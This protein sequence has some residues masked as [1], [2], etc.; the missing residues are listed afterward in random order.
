MN[1]NP[2]TPLARSPNPILAPQVVQTVD[3]S[4]LVEPVVLVRPKREAVRE[5]RELRCK[6]TAEEAIRGLSHDNEIY[7]FTKGQFSLLQLLTAC[8]QTTGPAHM[9]L[10]TWT[11]A[12]HEI[13]ALEKMQQAGTLLSA[14][15]LVDFT[16]AR[17]DPEAAGHI[18]KS[19]GVEA[20]RVAQTHSKF[21]L[22]ENDQWRLVIRTS[23]NL[24]MNPRFEDFTIAHDPLLADFLGRILDEIWA[25]QKRTLADAR[26]GEIRRHFL[27]DL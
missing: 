2:F 12:H 27:D 17:R 4:T 16:F 19:F 3:V 25:K 22:F 15:W 13:A 24:N 1:K 18:R 23:M 11:A 9:S 20:I 10:S 26:P 14:R 7:G 6:Q 21:C 5:L 8:L